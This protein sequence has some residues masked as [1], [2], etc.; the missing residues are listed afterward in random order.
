M[1]LKIY[2]EKEVET[3]LE[4]CELELVATPHHVEVVFAHEGFLVVVIHSLCSQKVA[5]RM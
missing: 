2:R 1:L 5:M 4:D 3:K